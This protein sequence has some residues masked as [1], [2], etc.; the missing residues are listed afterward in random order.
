MTLG[1]TNNSY[2][3]SQ[4]TTVSAVSGLTWLNTT[5]AVI[6]TTAPA[7]T[8]CPITTACDLTT[9]GYT[10]CAGGFTGALVCG[11]GDFVEQI[12][13]SVSTTFKLP[14]SSVS[15]TVYVTGASGTVAGPISYFTEGSPIT[16][17]STAENIVLDFDIGTEA[18]GPG[19]VTSVSVIATT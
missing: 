6:N 18:T 14:T 15:L 13:I 5:L 9:S 8:S 11:N 1:G 7:F 19:A 2:Q 10:V 3:G 17:P 12:T 4:T 16:A